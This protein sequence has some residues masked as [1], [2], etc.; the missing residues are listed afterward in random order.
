M[1]ENIDLRNVLVEI[2]I[3]HLLLTVCHSTRVH[4]RQYT[5]SVTKMTTLH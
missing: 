1:V 5:V 4:I 2:I 3:V